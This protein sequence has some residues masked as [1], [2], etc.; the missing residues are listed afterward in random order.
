MNV[1][2]KDIILT[3]TEVYVNDH[4]RRLEFELPEYVDT[5]YLDGIFEFFEKD[6]R[7]TLKL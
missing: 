6:I 7:V 1:I 4:I 5:S 3:L 2:K